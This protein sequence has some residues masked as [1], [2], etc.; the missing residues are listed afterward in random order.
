MIVVAAFM[1]AVE[2]LVLSCGIKIGTLHGVKHE[3]NSLGQQ[4]SSLRQLAMM[5][6]VAT[7]VGYTPV[8]AGEAMGASSILQELKNFSELGSV[9]YIAAHPDDENNRLLPYLARG[10]ALRTGYLSL[11]RGDGGQNLIG[12]ELG[13]QLGVIRT[14]ELIAARRVD[15]GQQFFTRA[16]DFGFSKDSA[17]TLRRWDRQ[18]VLSDMVRVIRKFQPDV[19]IARFSPVPGGTHGHHTASAILAIEAFDLAGNP[20]AYPEQL[21]DLQAWQPKR[22]FWNSFIRPGENGEGTSTTIRLDS[23]GYDPLLGESFG[24]IGARGRSMHKSQGEGRVGTRGPGWENFDLLAG[25]PAKND[26][27][28]GIDTKWSRI[29]GGADL[30]ELSH[31]LLTEFNPQKPSA[32][33]PALLDVRKRLAV[34]PDHPLLAEKRAQLDRILQACLG[35]FVD[36]VIPSAEAIA[37]Q[38]LAMKHSAVVRA[39]Y[40]IRWSGTR[41]PAL[42]PELVGEAIALSDNRLAQRETTRT[43]PANTPPSQPYWLRE[44][45]TEGMFRVDDE[46]LIG[47]SENPP[48]FP[49]EHVFELAGQTLVVTDEPV[50]VIND[51]VR[52]ELRRRIDVIPPVSLRWLQELEL[53]A[54]GETRSVSVEISAASPD[55]EGTLEL[56]APKGWTTKPS[57]HPFHLKG[58]G[59]RATFAFE[60]TAPRETSVAQ[61]RANALV[62]GVKYQT[63]RAEIRYDH[64]PFQLLQGPAQAKVVTLDVAIRGRNV[65][66]LPGAGDLVAESIARMG[67]VVTP[68]EPGDL[69][70]ESLRR[71]DAVVIGV[72]AFNTRGDMDRHMPTL[73]AYAEAGGN[74]IVQYNT[75]NGLQS[76]R[77]MPYPLE[78]SRDRVTNATAPVDLLAP[79][80][81]ALT[82]PNKITASDF[83]GWVQERARYVPRSWDPKFVPLLSMGDAGEDPLKGTL[84]VAP[85]GKGYVVYSGLS[86]FRELPAGV[87]GAYRLFANLLSLGK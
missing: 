37:G 12:T 32:S 62:G 38:T 16:R 27:L 49:V 71:F 57:S 61:L 55:V 3:R 86:W 6:I 85:H 8:Q 9:L 5:T 50:Q 7:A 65:G 78:L 80:H 31:S 75:S 69:N 48:A 52:G 70:S 11:T 53:L 68:L 77:F 43:L 58:S 28:D 41:Y 4:Q 56:Q 74:L 47:C 23:G 21:A 83:E 10:R 73:F 19:V 15:G 22:L 81:P 13:E 35:L 18:Q 36:T 45:G 72:R 42:A 33:I 59:A 2:R 54:P 60:V 64:I 63:T 40:P 87:P 25:S 66:Y 79:E 1:T 29:P 34:L 30:D 14:H 67:Y 20:A 17:D 26:I 76:T 44:E 24:E 51:P 82:S 39:D 84:L 46:K